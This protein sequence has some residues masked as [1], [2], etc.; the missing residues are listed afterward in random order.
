[1][2]KPSFILLT[3]DAIPSNVAHHVANACRDMFL[4]SGEGG[5]RE[6]PASSGQ[7]VWYRY[8]D[9]AALADGFE[10]YGRDGAMDAHFHCGIAMPCK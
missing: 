10:D 4:D 2:R 3:L 8:D 5:T 9:A 7:F 1:M 6:W